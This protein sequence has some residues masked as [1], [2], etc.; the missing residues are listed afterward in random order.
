MLDI[1]VT[2]I[3]TLEEELKIRW[4]YGYDE[5]KAAGLEKGAAQKQREIAKN[6]KH[7]G[8]PV[9]V[10]AENTGLT[11]E[12]IEKS[13]GSLKKFVVGKAESLASKHKDRKAGMNVKSSF[14]L[15]R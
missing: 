3:M 1:R 4:H 10:I 11:A 2:E 9:D 6:L 5:G 7:A 15:F 13:I 12:E 14:L 8:I